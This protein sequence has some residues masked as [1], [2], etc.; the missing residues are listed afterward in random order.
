ME[1]RS[2]DPAIL[3]SVHWVLP[4]TWR[5]SSTGKPS[6]IFRLQSNGLILR[7]DRECAFTEDPAPAPRGVHLAEMLVRLGEMV[8]EHLAV[9]SPKHVFLHAGTVGVNGRGIVVPG[10]SRSGKTS[11]IQGL[12]GSG[13]DYYSDEYAVVDSNGLLHPYPRPPSVRINGAERRG[14]PVPIPAER[15]GRRPLSC[16]LI[17]FTV[18]EPGGG[19]APQ[20]M[21]AG[22]AALG[23]LEHA[24][25]VRARPQATLTAVRQLAV[26]AT[27][28]TSPRGEAH[29]TA[30]ELLTFLDR[31]D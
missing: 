8:Q 12:V 28:V 23:L 7:E 14:V 16:R 9:R 30:S 13:A 10:R 27:A 19:W 26:G 31:L 17:V 6:A 2:E 22:Q 11:L 5:R 1:V 15:V 18:F 20:R 25:P 24:V 21:S 4:P 29:A 3:D